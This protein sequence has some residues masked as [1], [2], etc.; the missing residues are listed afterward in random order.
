M[1]RH[2][3]HGYIV[4]YFKINCKK[5]KTVSCAITSTAQIHCT[6]HE[7]NTMNGIIM[8]PNKLIDTAQT[9]ES[10]IETK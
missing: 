5:Q 1:C 10:P 2:C 8:D 3:I 4:L 6:V 7:I 9:T